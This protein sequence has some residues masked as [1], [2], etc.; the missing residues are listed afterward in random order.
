MT[1]TK[2]DFKVKNYCEDRLGYYIMV[3]GQNTKSYNI[4]EAI[5]IQFKE[6]IEN[7]TIIFGE[8]NTHL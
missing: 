6:E 7:S 3:K 5:L 4:Y 2:V 1:I 8:S